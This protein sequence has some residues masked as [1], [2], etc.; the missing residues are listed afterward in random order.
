MG[1][2]MQ[3][4]H[5]RTV[6]AGI[7]M[8]AAPLLVGIGTLMG[9]VTGDDTTEAVTE[10]AADADAV[11]V[12]S[13]ITLVGLVLFLPVVM[14][15]F[16]LQREKE[17]WLGQIGGLL[18]GTGIVLVAVQSGVVATV[19]EVAELDIATGRAVMD[20]L[21]SNPVVVFGVAGSIAFAV[22]FLVLAIG[23][24]RARTAPRWPARLVALGATLAVVGDLAAVDAI[25]VA[26]NGALLL[27]LVPLGYQLMAESDETRVHPASFEGI[28]PK[29]GD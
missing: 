1:A 22:G 12:A 29:P 13:L 11:Y 25:D 4:L 6:F 17:P 2:T 23:L 18:G 16:R 3:E 20:S 7:S 26:G 21:E 8:I 24:L 19:T 5:R 27:G 14:A 15:L 28:R 10:L 9:P